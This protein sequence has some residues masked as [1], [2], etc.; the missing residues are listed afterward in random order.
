MAARI[1]KQ[2][3][4]D[5]YKKKLN[6]EMQEKFAKKGLLKKMFDANKK[7]TNTLVEILKESD[8]LNTMQNNN[9]SKN[10]NGSST[11]TS[12]TKPDNEQFLK[13]YYQTQTGG[14]KH[15]IAVNRAHHL[16]NFLTE[17]ILNAFQSGHFESPDLTPLNLDPK[18]EDYFFELSRIELL[19][20]LSAIKVYWFNS[21]IEKIDS[22]VEVFLDKKLKSQIRQTLINEKVMNYVPKVVFVRDET[23]ALM[24]Q[25]DESLAQ[26]KIETSQYEKSINEV[27]TENEESSFKT[28]ENEKEKIN[29][30]RNSVKKVIN[31]VYGVDF[32][33]LL[34]KIKSGNSND[35]TKWSPT[36]PENNS[37]LQAENAPKPSNLTLDTALAHVEQKKFE[38][39]LKAF[40]LNRKQKMERLNKSAI[41]KL[42]HLELQEFKNNQ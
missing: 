10:N 23:N 39:S 38:S 41:L 26:I 16:T 33:K 32:N 2:L 29:S 12:S 34:E 37:E 15:S 42:C 8:N 20:D 5:A 30:S 21:G 14:P 3:V 18:T 36:S 31:N 13:K 24:K 17:Y 1:G 9:Y 25:L 27:N 6:K 40:Q 19:T 22:Y 4:L 28:I 11:T 7:R 35:Y